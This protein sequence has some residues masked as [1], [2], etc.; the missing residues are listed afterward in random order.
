MLTYILNKLNQIMSYTFSLVSFATK[1]ERSEAVE[2]GQ[3]LK[4]R[5]LETS[6]SIQ[7]C[8]AL[9]ISFHL[10]YVKMLILSLRFAS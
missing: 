3:H 7:S 4:D 1:N 6:P 9:K 10:S 8:P 5:G 2:V